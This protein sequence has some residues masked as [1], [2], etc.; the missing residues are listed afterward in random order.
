[1][2][3][4]CAGRRKL[5]RSNNDL[6]HTI[7]TGTKVANRWRR[8]SGRAIRPVLSQAG[9][10]P[11]NPEWCVGRRDACKDGGT[12]ASAPLLDP[13]HRSGGTLS[14][15]G[16]TVG[17]DNAAGLGA[18]SGMRRVPDETGKFACEKT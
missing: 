4:P 9:M 16:R 3:S 14:P 10:R 1:M 15:I 17:A 8:H 5:A 11:P 18:H 7:K 12:V 2:G 13:H 6:A